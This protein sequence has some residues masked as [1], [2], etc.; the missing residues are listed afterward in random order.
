MRNYTLAAGVYT[1]PCNVFEERAK[2]PKTNLYGRIVGDV[3]ILTLD[4][5]GYLVTGY[6]DLESGRFHGEMAQQSHRRNSGDTLAIEN[7]LLDVCLT[8][9]EDPEIAEHL[10]AHSFQT[11][12]DFIR[13]GPPPGPAV[14]KG[15]LSRVGR[16]SF[17][18]RP[19]T[20]KSILLLNWAIAVAT[21]QPWLGRQVERGRVLLFLL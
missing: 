20:G 14:V 17:A 11:A 13:G 1:F 4:G 3:E 8:L 5:E 21:E 15:L 16:Y 6:G 19:K 12:A 10:P 18:A 7:E 2:H 9:R